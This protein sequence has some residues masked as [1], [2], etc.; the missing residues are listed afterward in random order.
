MNL[1]VVHTIQVMLPYNVLIVAM[2]V[3]LVGFVIFRVSVK[4]LRDFLPI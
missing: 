3:F 2:L 4:L 1:A